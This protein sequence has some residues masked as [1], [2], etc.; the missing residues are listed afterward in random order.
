MLNRWGQAV[1]TKAS[2]TFHRKSESAGVSD[3]RTLAENRKSLEEK[4]LRPS[5]YHPAFHAHELFDHGF[6]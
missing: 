2:R 1:G 5:G 6:W 4:L 3:R